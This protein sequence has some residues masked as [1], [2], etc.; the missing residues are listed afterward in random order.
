[1]AYDKIVAMLNKLP[2]AGGRLRNADDE[3]VNAESV[4][5]VKAFLEDLPDFKHHHGIASWHEGSKHVLK[6]LDNIGGTFATELLRRR[7]VMAGQRSFRVTLEPSTAQQKLQPNAT[8]PN[9]IWHV[10]VDDNCVMQELRQAIAKEGNYC[11]SADIAAVKSLV[12]TGNFNIGQYVST[13]G[14][15]G[16]MSKPQLAYADTINELVC[17]DGYYDVYV[18]RKSPRKTRSRGPKKPPK[19]PPNKEDSVTVKGTQGSQDGNGTNGAGNKPSSSVKPNTCVSGKKRPLEPNTDRSQRHAKRAEAQLQRLP[20]PFV[21]SQSA[22]QSPAFPDASH[23]PLQQT[24]SNTSVMSELDT[25]NDKDILKTLL[26]RMGHVHVVTLGNGFCGYFCLSEMSRVL[27][28]FQII[29]HWRAVFVSR[30][31]SNAATDA[32]KAEVLSVKSNGAKDEDAQANVLGAKK[33][34]AFAKE[35]LEAS[36]HIMSTLDFDYKC[37]WSQPPDSTKTVS[38]EETANTLNEGVSK[39]ASRLKGDSASTTTVSIYKPD[40]VSIAHSKPKPTERL[41]VMFDYLDEEIEKDKRNSDSSVYRRLKHVIGL[42]QAGSHYNGNGYAMDP[43][44]QFYLGEKGWVNDSLVDLQ[45]IVD[46]VDYLVID[47][48]FLTLRKAD[49]KQLVVGRPW[50][51]KLQ[52]PAKIGP[53]TQYPAKMHFWQ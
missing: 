19:K 17:N 2:A 53:S 11:A 14:K 34:A 28:P 18:V 33:A 48:S 51:H 29:Q 40:A 24:L 35:A 44:D 9:I 10:V 45:A 52:F 38:I 37:P 12:G 50:A 7:S 22:G 1:M 5:A 41:Q 43:T 25:S 42:L 46:G 36:A 16:K 49:G 3:K 4:K 8:L 13:E 23:P 32:K 15:K 6:K 26:L 47:G 39:K 27:S 30:V 21:P 31:A 20:P